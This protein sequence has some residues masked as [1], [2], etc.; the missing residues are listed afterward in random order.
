MS[1]FLDLYVPPAAKGKL[2]TNYTLTVTPYQVERRVTSHLWTNYTLTVTPYQVGRRVTSHLWRNYTLTV[3]P[4]QVGRQVTSGRIAHSIPGWKASHLWTN[5]TLTVTP[6]Q[7]GRQVTSGRITHS[8][9]GWKAS[10]QKKH[11]V[12]SG[13]IT[14]SQSPGRKASHQKQQQGNLWSNYTLTVTPYQVG[15]LVTKRNREAVFVGKTAKSVPD[16]VGGKSLPPRSRPE[17]ER[18]VAECT[19]DWA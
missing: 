15:R 17:A 16:Q 11:R 8:I 3:T 18:R 19:V 4:Y 1:Y 5:Y 6:Y 7:I 13:R 9:P 2:W 12:T 14:H 10:H